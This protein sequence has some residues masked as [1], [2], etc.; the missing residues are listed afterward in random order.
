MTS[1]ARV[2]AAERAE[3][4][5]PNQ[6]GGGSIHP[7]DIQRFVPVPGHTVTKR[8]RPAGCEYVVLVG[9][10]RGVT[11]SVEVGVRYLKSGNDHFGAEHGVQGSLHDAGLHVPIRSHTHYLVASMDTRV[12]TPRYMGS[13]GAQDGSERILQRTLHR[14]QPGLSGVPGE[15]R[16]VVTEVEPVVRH[17][18]AR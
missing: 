6:E 9:P 16:A 3:V 18:G 15:S 11:T 8:I 5:F 14:P 1:L 4:V 7:V 13:D 10:A 12:G 17:K 2:F